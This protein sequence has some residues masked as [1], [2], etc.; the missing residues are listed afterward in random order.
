MH[1]IDWQPRTDLDDAKAHP[2]TGRMTGPG[3]VAVIGDDGGP[4]RL[5][6]EQ[7]GY[8]AA[9]VSDAQYVLYVA[10]SH[11]ANTT[12]TD[13]DFAVRIS[14]EVSGLVRTLAERYA[15][16]PA[17]LWIVTRGVHESVA[18]SALR[19]SFL[20]GFAGVI[21][22]EHPELWGGLVDLAVDGDLDDAAPALADLLQ[23]PSKSIL[24]LRDGVVLAPTLAPVS[25]QAGAQVP[26]MQARCRLPHHRWNGRTWSADGRLARRPRRSSIGTDRPYAVAAKAGLGTRH[27]RRRTAPE[28]RRNSR[29]GN[30]GCDSR[31]RRRRH[32]MPRR[33]AGPVGQAR[34][35]TELHRSAG[36]S[37]RQ[38]S[39]TINW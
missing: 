9:A 4:L 14:A 27:P 25:R 31:S 19:Q 6:L 11:P 22:A 23:T 24:V 32:R 16:K 3:P 8:A 21:A 2:V 7:A 1:T 10:D 26:A 34:S 33:R 28:D 17:A 38:A 5:R 30:A 29:P 18:P 37:M 36:S 13:V 39:R 35:M 20:W 12:E 15:D